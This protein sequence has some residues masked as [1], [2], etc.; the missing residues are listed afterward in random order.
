MLYHHQPG[1]SG[2]LF[3]QPPPPPL[4]PSYLSRPSVCLSLTPRKL[5]LSHSLIFFHSHSSVPTTQ[6]VAFLSYSLLFVGILLMAFWWGGGDILHFT[7]NPFCM[8]LTRHL[9]VNV[10]L[11]I[12]IS[13]VSGQLGVRSISFQ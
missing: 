6:K 10:Y 12:S 7:P 8:L 2:H 3:S 5:F 13:V 4:H 11:S 9:T 1:L